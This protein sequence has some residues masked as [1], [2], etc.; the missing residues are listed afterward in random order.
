MTDPTRRKQPPPA[1]TLDP[2]SNAPPAPYVRWIWFDRRRGAARLFMLSFTVPFQAAFDA[3][4]GA[5]DYSWMLLLHDA[6]ATGR[7]FGTRIILP[8]GPLGFIGTDVYD[9]RTYWI[10]IA[11]RTA[12]RPCRVL[13][14]LGNRAEASVSHALLAAWM[15]GGHHPVDWRFA[16]SFLPRVHTFPAADEL[17]C[18][19]RASTP[20][21]AAIG[22]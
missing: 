9:P 2:C 8:Q 22:G 6:V 14:D 10:L 4:T 11:A 17:F 20:P 5:F 3:P 18:G 16:G 1:K 19:S 13:V 12:I 7:Q 21:I 15:A